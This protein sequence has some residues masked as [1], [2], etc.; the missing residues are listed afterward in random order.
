MLD[1]R[2]YGPATALHAH[3]FVQVVMPSRGVLEIEVNG[4]GGRVDA[5][6]I[7]VIPAGVA[8]AFEATGR[9]SFIVLDAV[10]ATNAPDLSRLGD[11]VFIPLMPSL[12]ALT[13]WLQTMH[14]PESVT[15]IDSALADAWSSLA[16]ATL[17]SHPANGGTSL[18]ARRDPRAERVWRAINQR[19]AEPLTIDALAA[20]EGVS[21]RH[22]AALFRATYGTTVHAR[23]AEVRVQYAVSLLETTSLPIIEVAARS[24]YYDQSSLT[25]HLRAALGTTPGAL[26][27]HRR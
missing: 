16:L 14:A 6:H 25:R 19:F 21:G 24:G 9:N 1:F 17:A 8:H 10:Q 18:R 3:D 26:R 20:E 12:R 22:L 23:L 11:R 2:S 5:R 15:A 13:T 7:A 27:R 4:R